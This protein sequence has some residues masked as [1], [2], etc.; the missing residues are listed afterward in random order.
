MIGMENLLLHLVSLAQHFSNFSKRHIVEIFLLEIGI[1]SKKDSFDYLVDSVLIQAETD[2]SL[3]TKNVYPAVA[4]TYGMETK[5]VEKAIER[6]IRQAWKDR[7][8]K[9]DMYFLNVNQVTSGEFVARLAKIL[10]FWED[11]CKTVVQ[12]EG[13]KCRN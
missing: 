12:K 13:S 3:V 11:I 8:E 1:N 2:C 6:A 10:G 9:W 5:A 7:D 4:S